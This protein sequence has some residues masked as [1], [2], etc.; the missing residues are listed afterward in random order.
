MAASFDPDKANNKLAAPEALTRKDLYGN[1]TDVRMYPSLHL[2]GRMRPMFINAGFVIGTVGT[3]KPL[4]E[5]AREKVIVDG[6]DHRGSDQYVFQE[7]FGQQQ[8]WRELRRQY[9]RSIIQK[10]LDV[11]KQTLGTLALM[12]DP[13][14]FHKPA[15]VTARKGDKSRFEYSMGL[16]YNLELSQA[17]S[18]AD[19]DG[20]FV[21]YADEAGKQQT[22]RGPDMPVPPRVQKLP[23]DIA[24]DISLPDIDWAQQFLYTNV[25]TSAVPVTLHFNGD[26]GKRKTVWKEMWFFG[27]AR[28]RFFATRQNPGIAKDP[29]GNVLRWNDICQQFEEKIF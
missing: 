12:T 6:I 1:L 2:S 9:H 23:A 11:Y 19:E 20:V 29:E 14:P 24:N 17:R 10:V 16:D 18:H 4:L 8:Y 5:R 21:V 22:L 25:Y 3:M 28:E 7:V 15:N 27:T 26:K 13:H